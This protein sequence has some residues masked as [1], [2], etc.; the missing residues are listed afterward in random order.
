MN[1][2]HK[3]FHAKFGIIDRNS[4]TGMRKLRE[5][6]SLSAEELR[7]LNWN[8]RVDLVRFCAEKIPFYQRKFDEI[9]FSPDDLKEEADFQRLPILEKEDVRSFTHELINPD[10]DINKLTGATTGGTTGEPLKTYSDP[11]IHLSSMSWRMLNWWGVDVS[12]NSGYLYRAIPVGVKKLAMDIALWPTRRSYIAAADMTHQNMMCFYR[13]LKRTNSKYLVGYVGAIDEFARFIQSNGYSLP[14]LEA[15]WTTSAPLPATKRSDYERIF[16]C[17]VYTQYGSCEFYW[18]AA[19]CRHQS[20]LHIGSDIRHVDIVDGSTP[21]DHGSFGDIVVTDLLN[22]TFP[23]LR[24]RIGDRGRLLN[25]QCDCGLPFPM[26][27]YVKGRVS[28]AILL[29]DGTSIPGEYWTT[30]FDDFTDAI[31]SFQVH[32]K[33]DHSLV[34]SYECYAG[35]NASTVVST[36]D[37]RLAEKI[38]NRI[39]YE[40]KEADVT[41]HDNGKIRFV[42]SEL[43]R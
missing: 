37:S 28:D 35:K 30:I 42:T 7:R 14:S 38:K 27:D 17:P 9:G 21:V 18:I 11:E 29:P 4:Q 20:G 23:L 15:I 8:R 2:R 22:Y 13:K 39:T 1:I 33:L 41:G 5:G 26:M 19:E 40:F 34:I 16:A 25:R 6:E 12:D 10:Y 31:R 32:Q 43:K 24:Y 36:V 3:A